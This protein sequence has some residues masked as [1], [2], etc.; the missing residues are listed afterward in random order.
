[1]NSTPDSIE[2]TIIVVV[3]WVRL[4]VEVFGAGL[5]TRGVCVAIAQLIRTLAARKLAEFTHKRFFAGALC[6]GLEIPES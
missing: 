2:G 5:V 3:R 1:M 6:C 4:G